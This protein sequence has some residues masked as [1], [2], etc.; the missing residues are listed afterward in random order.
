ME[1]MSSG[2]PGHGLGAHRKVSHRL[3]D[4]PMES[5][6]QKENGLA[7]DYQS[8]Y[9]FKFVGFSCPK[10][11]AQICEIVLRGLYS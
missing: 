2:A 1:A 3:Q 5:P 4:F 7:T 9:I 11:V 6:L 8:Y 10:N